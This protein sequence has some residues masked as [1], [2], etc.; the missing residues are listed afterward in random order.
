MESRVIFEGPGPFHLPV[1]QRAS[2]EGHTNNGIT[3]TLY[4]LLPAHDA[5]SEAMRS[6]SPEAVNVQM[7]SKVARELAVQLI[8][9]ADKADAELRDRA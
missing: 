1:A 9:A 3:L 7:P 2:A 5:S 8:R 6:K 4:S